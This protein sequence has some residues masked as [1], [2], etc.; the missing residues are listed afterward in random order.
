MIT[1]NSTCI[2]INALG[3]VVVLAV[4][5]MVIAIIGFFNHDA[6]A[7]SFDIKDQVSCQS[8]P[9]GSPSWDPSTNTCT[10]TNISLTLNS[11][12]SL[13]VENGI[14]FVINSG[15]ILLNDG[16][17]MSNSGII[18]DNSGIFTSLPGLVNAGTIN[19]NAGG[20][21]NISS[22]G[23]IFNGYLTG[24]TNTINNYGTINNIGELAND[25]GHINNYA[26]LNNNQGGGFDSSDSC[27]INN[28]PDGTITNSAR[29]TTDS[30]VIT[31]SG[32]INNNSEGN[33]HIEDFNLIINSG[34]INNSG[35]II[36]EVDSTIN[37]TGTINNSGS[38]NTNGNLTN[39][40]TITNSG[41]I[42]NPGTINNSGT[43]INEVESIISNTGTINNLCPDGVINQN[44]I[45][46]G[47]PIN[48]IPCIDTIQPDTSIT[49]ALDHKGD[50]VPSGGTT[51]SPTIKFTF[52]G[53]DNAGVAGFE[54]SLDGS[55]FTPCTGPVTYDKLPNGIHTF[56]VRAVDTSGNVDPLPATFSWTRGK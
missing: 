20:I 11:G 25:G 16:S 9:S 10:V 46:S 40:G 28:N 52:T 50:S 3:W 5:I 19:N 35:T 43:I 27:S 44:G 30:C 6:Y 12:D 34:T 26:I 18:N 32:T 38:F 56:Q 7:A 37:N 41:S 39:S 1:L 22:G 17:I 54:C 47:N 4:A 29:L 21:I 14:V 23:G 31:N 48:N 55:L 2:T 45:L 51:H 53:T 15:F 13:T 8:L 33:I 49:S 36:I 24:A 42:S